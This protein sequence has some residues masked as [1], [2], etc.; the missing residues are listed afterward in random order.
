MSRFT[1]TFLLIIIGVTSCAPLKRSQVILVGNYFNTIAGYPDYI[2]ELNAYQ[3]DLTLQADNLHSSLILSD[4]LRIAALIHAV[5]QYENEL[6]FPDSIATSLTD[7]EAYIRGYYILAPNGFDL[8]KTI[9]STTESIGSM[10]GL[11]AVV[12]ALLPEARSNVSDFKKRKIYAHFSSQENALQANLQNLKLHIDLHM[13]GHIDSVQAQVRRDVQLLFIHEGDPITPLDYYFNYN[14]YFSDY[15]QRINKIRKLAISV[16]TS[17]DHI[18]KTEAEIK[19]MTSQR[20]KIQRDSRKLHQLAD[21][22]RMIQQI[23]IELASQKLT[24][25]PLKLNERNTKVGSNK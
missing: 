5:Q 6:V 19:S 11:K 23:R 15:F 8:Y 9:K 2:R 7:L 22:V 3:A 16:S 20:Q 10:F 4:T 13:I 25:Q 14:Q 1:S 24:R 12:S 21:D 17:L 18:I